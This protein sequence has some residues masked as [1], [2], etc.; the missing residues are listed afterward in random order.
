MRSESFFLSTTSEFFA[1]MSYRGDEMV[2][3]WNMPKPIQGSFISLQNYSIKSRNVNSP[4]RVC[5]NLVL[6]DWK[7]PDGCL[8]DI[9]HG[10]W[11]Y[12]DDMWEMEPRDMRSIV[13]K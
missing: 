10:Q 5:C 4:I 13:L 2:L 3:K 11:I 12:S 8:G 6:A 7:N 9:K 1:G